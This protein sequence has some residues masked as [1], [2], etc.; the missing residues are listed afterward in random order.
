MVDLL[1]ND[2]RVL[3]FKTAPSDRNGVSAEYSLQLTTPE[4]RLPGR[5][6][7]LGDAYL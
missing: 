5:S 2:G 7:A 3:D 6:K 1:D 4:S